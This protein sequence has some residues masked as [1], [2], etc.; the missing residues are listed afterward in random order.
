MAKVKRIGGEPQ[1]R[2]S[3]TR[4]EKFWVIELVVMKPNRC[5]A[6][7]VGPLLFFAPFFFSCFST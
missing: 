7:G 6:M 2:S 1:S 5:K 3:I 4:C